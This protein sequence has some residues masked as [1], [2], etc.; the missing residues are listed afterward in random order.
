M[1]II[2]IMSFFT[3]GHNSYSG[4]SV[5][6]TMYLYIYLYL[7]LEDRI[8]YTLKIMLYKY[9]FCLHVYMIMFVIQVLAI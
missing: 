5:I 3:S 1:N 7:E 4:T 6:R 8:F 9:R 2:R